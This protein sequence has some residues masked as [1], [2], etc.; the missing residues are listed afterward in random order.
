M[1][2][3]TFYCD[4][5]EFGGHEILTVE[6]AKY[7]CQQKDLEISF[8]FYEGNRRLGE[9]LLLIAEEGGNISLHPIKFRSRR[10]QGL[11]TLFSWNAVIKLQKILRDLHPDMVIITQGFIESGSLGLIASKRSGYRT[12][13]YIPFAHKISDIGKRNGGIIRDL[14]NLYYYSLPDHFITLSNTMRKMLIDRGVV[15]QISVVFSGLDFTKL[16]AYDRKACRLPFDRTESVYLIGCIGRIY[17]PHKAQDFL[18][19]ALAKNRQR[20]E[21]IKLLIV[22]DG[23]DLG[24]L[25]EMIASLRLQDSVTLVPWSNDLSRIYSALD[26]LVIPSWFEG[27]PLVMLEAMF[28]SIPIVASNVD[29]MAEILPPEWLFKVG[30]AE[31]LVDTLLALREKDNT[32]AIRQNKRLVGKEFTLDKFGRNFLKAITGVC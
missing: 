23:P 2:R 24:R 3:L 14:L 1:K 9:R 20:L 8:I 19:Q 12:I 26:L 31:S 4:A 28:Y 13:S 17:F 27:V 11:R 30:D 16:K 32:G 15:S 5:S 29:G 22:G 6:A 21:G 25:K 18:V 7:L 10:L